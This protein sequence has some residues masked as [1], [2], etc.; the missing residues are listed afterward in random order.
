MEGWRFAKAGQDLRMGGSMT[1]YFYLTNKFI[2]SW[3]QYS[4]EEELIIKNG[5][6]H[7]HSVELEGTLEECTPQLDDAKNDMQNAVEATLRLLDQQRLDLEQARML[8]TNKGGL[9]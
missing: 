6:I 2:C 4:E 9:N 1:V 3:T 8:L 5:G 7:I